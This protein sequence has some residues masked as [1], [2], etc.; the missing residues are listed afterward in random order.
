ME[1][2]LFTGLRDQVRAGK[3]AGAGYKAE[4]WTQVIEAVRRATR[5]SHSVSKAQCQTKLDSYKTLWRIWHFLRT[6]SGWGFDEETQLFI[7][8]DNQWREQIKVILTIVKKHT[9]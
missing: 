5:P 2:A 8:D 1:E 6:L 3:E 9:S 7:A 4:A